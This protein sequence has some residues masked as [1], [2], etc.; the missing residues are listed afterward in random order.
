[1][2]ELIVAMALSTILLGLVVTGSMFLKKYINQWQERDRLLEETLFIQEELSRSIG[3]SQQITIHHDSLVCLDRRLK[4]T[5][6]GWE[7]N[8]LVKNG[9][10]LS[11]SS[12]SLD[13]VA[14]SKMDLPPQASDTILYERG[15]VKPS[16]IY[17]LA[18]VVS[19]SRGNTDSL[20][21]LIRN[22]YECIKYSPF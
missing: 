20:V 2:A 16:G 13:G 17:R 21:T 15:M 19:D 10:P 8:R 12:L 3:Q 14:I 22:K 11:Q 6:Y 9:R 7:N 4:T 1:M 5:V 18:V